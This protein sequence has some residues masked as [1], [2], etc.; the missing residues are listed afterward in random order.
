MNSCMFL[1]GLT[2]L[3]LRVIAFFRAGATGFTDGLMKVVTFLGEPY[4]LVLLVIALFFVCDRKTGEKATFVL[5]ASTAVNNLLKAIVR[6]PRPFVNPAADFTPCEG[7]LATATGYSFPS[8]HTQVVSVA[9]FTG[10]TLLKK[11]WAYIVAT[12]ITVLVALSRVALGV[13]YPKDVICGALIGLVFAIFG[14]RFV[15]KIWDDEKKRNLTLLVSS[16]CLALAGILF[17]FIT[18][19]AGIEDYFKSLGLFLGYAL[20]VFLLERT[21]PYEA[22]KSLGKR[23]LRAAIALVVAGITYLGLKVLFSLIASSAYLD[24]LRY[25]MVPFLALWLYPFLARK[26]ALFA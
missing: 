4:I 3:E 6:C 12:I 5:L 11:R 20:A 16:A 1:S 26:T 10:A 7:A 8:G 2:D 24:M 25:F 22:K 9:S 17:A 18:G 13:H 21:A 15:Q 19:P 14:M 23:L